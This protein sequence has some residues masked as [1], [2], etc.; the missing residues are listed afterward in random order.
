M[1]RKLTCRAL[2]ERYSVAI[3]VKWADGTVIAELPTPQERAVAQLAVI[4]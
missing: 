3:I 2:Q 1:T 4:S